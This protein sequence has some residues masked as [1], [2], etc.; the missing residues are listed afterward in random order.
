MRRIFSH[1]YRRIGFGVLALA[2]ALGLE[3]CFAPVEANS[4]S[5]HVDPVAMQLQQSSEGPKTLTVWIP[6]QGF[7]SEGARQTASQSSLVRVWDQTAVKQLTLQYQHND[8][9]GWVF[10]ATG[11]QGV[12]FSAPEI[13]GIH[14]DAS[15]STLACAGQGRLVQTRGSEGCDYSAW[16]R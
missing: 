6:N 8:G 3:Q 2:L 12:R 13:Q 7:V 16:A 5:G 10:M 4:G 15:A 9:G 14:V 1:G 11:V